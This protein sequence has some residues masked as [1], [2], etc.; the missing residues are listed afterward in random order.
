MRC[1]I[2]LLVLA[3]LCVCVGCG[4]NAGIKGLVNVTGTVNYQGKPVD[5]ATV[6]FAPEGTGRAASGRTDAS[7]KFR[8]TTL[9]ENDGALPG[10]YK[11]SVSKVEN[12]DA[13]SQLTA[14]DM[15]KMV[16]GGKAA[17]SGPTPSKGGQSGGIK[18]HVPEKYETPDKSGLT[19]EV[20]DGGAND[21]TFDL[22]D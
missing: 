11:V 4:G 5:G 7:G 18:H 2:R 22:V 17:P 9:N 13:A 15:A 3:G 8:L 6:S 21:F 19:A 14:E 1:G 10:K 12:L 16:G 20:T